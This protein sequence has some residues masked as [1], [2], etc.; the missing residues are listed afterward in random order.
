MVS[1]ILKCIWPTELRANR[2]K[3][4]PMELT[5]DE[6]Y[7]IQPTELIDFAELIAN[8]AKHTA[9]FLFRGPLSLEQWTAV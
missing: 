7:S 1:R 3:K 2:A 8:K 5:A 9:E 6:A 4:K